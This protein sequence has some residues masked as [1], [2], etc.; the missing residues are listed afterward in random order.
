MIV[1]PPLLLLF[2]LLYLCT[3]NITIRRHVQ[4]REAHYGYTHARK[5]K[6]FF[7]HLMEEEGINT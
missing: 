7:I 3:M 5:T 1:S 6:S 4:S 2:S